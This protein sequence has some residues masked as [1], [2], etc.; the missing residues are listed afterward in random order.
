MTEAA[1][2]SRHP[3]SAATPDVDPV[4]AT[5]PEAEPA[6]STER[7][8]AIIPVLR[9]ATGF[10][11]LWAFLDKLFGLGY[12]T[13][14]SAAWINGGSPTNGF[15]SHVAVGPFQSTLQSW[16]G[17]AWADWLFMLGLLG[18]GVALILGVAMRLAAAA[19]VIMLALM[20]IAE[21]PLARH[22]S[23]GDP[24]GSTNPLVDY[25]VMYA[26]AAV[27]VAAV[28]GAGDRW[29]FGRQWR[30]LSVVRNHPWL[31]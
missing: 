12:S 5:I 15:L 18:V 30:Q 22:T 4:P 17:D 23:S 28:A 13:T 7:V 14:W 29:G 27:T 24:S 6:S 16:A 19:A 3:L 31:R 2:R 9:I 21:W 26:L 10:V 1:D 8:P 20:W 25:H 11:F